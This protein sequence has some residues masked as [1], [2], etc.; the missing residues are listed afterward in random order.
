MPASF[1]RTRPIWRLPSKNPT[2]ETCAVLPAATTSFARAGRQAD[3]L[4]V[5]QLTDGPFRT[6]SRKPANLV[7]GIG[8]LSPVSAMFFA[9]WKSEATT[10]MNSV[11]ARRGFSSRGIGKTAIPVAGS[12]LVAPYCAVPTRRRRDN[13]ST[14]D[15]ASRTLATI[16]GLP[17]ETRVVRTF[18]FGGFTSLTHER[19]TKR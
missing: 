16:D 9:S 13:G 12:N 4:G 5:I 8:L 14:P 1:F 6:A 18:T 11:P 19:R 2:E 3:L 10:R 7:F 17:A 15:L